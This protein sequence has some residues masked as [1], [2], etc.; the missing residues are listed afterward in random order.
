MA[1]PLLF[2]GG[3]DPGLW[4]PIVGIE[5]FDLPSFDVVVTPWF[6]LLC[7]GKLH[8]FSLKV[9]GFDTSAAGNIGSVR[10]N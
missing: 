10:E 1:I 4:R 8:D 9:V 5:A 6:P 2:T 3:V 7:D